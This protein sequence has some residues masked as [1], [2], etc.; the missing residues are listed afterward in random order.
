MQGK[1]RYFFA[2]IISGVA[3]V[4]VLSS[5]KKDTGTS[6]Q[7]VTDVQKIKLK[8]VTVQGLPS[9]YFQYKYDANDFVTELNHE[10]GFYQYRIEYKNGRISKMINNT[11]VNKDTLVYYYSG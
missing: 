3:M 9:P 1:W 6:H 7:P 8:E 10:S 2:T 11:V 4:S 5:C